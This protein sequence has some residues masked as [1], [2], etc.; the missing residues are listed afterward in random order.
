VTNLTLKINI[1]SAVFH[2]TVSVQILNA[3]GVPFLQFNYMPE[4]LSLILISGEWRWSEMRLWCVHG[5]QGFCRCG[6]L[7]ASLF[8]F[9][10]VKSE[11]KRCITDCNN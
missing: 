10:C 7:L 2:H 11:M 9:V 4:L 6:C 5:R 3:I 1:Y 8:C